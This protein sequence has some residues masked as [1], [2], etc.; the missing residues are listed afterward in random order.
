MLY[1]KHIIQ[2]PLN[3]KQENK[4]TVQDKKKKEN[5]LCQ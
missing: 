1:N 4:K 5:K 3:R 2:K